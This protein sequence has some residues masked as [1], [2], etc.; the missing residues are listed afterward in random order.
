MVLL[1][2]MAWAIVL[3]AYLNHVMSKEL[4]C[5]FLTGHGFCSFL[6]LLLEKVE[7]TGIC[8]DS[9]EI[10][11]GCEANSRLRAGLETRLASATG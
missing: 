4:P 6:C 1:A 8:L 3:H 11:C 7:R 9:K 5:C 10:D 2:S